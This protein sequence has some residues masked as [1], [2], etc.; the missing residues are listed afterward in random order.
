MYLCRKLSDQFVTWSDKL[1]PIKV[2]RVLQ[3]ANGSN[4]VH[5]ILTPYKLQY[6]LEYQK[7]AT[8]FPAILDGYFTMVH[9]DCFVSGKPHHR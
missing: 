9:S 6:H 4:Y 7:P 5:K 8:D 3:L 2:F 1:S